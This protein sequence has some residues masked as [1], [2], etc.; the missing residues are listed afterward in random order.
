MDLIPVY[1]SRLLTALL[2]LVLV[3][4]SCEATHSTRDCPQTQQAFMAFFNSGEHHKISSLFKENSKTKTQFK[5]LAQDLEYMREVA[6]KILSMEV[7]YTEGNKVHYKSTLEATALDISFIYNAKCQLTSLLIKNHFPEDLP[8]LERNSTSM[9]LPFHGEWY[10][11][12]GGPTVAQ[13]YHNAHQ[14][15]RGAFDFVMIDQRGKSYNTDGKKNEDYYAFG[16]EII[17]PCNAKV[18]RVIRGIKDNVW[19]NMNTV[20]A[21]GNAV[22]LK[23]KGNEFLFFAH[24][25]EKSIVV[26]EGDQV[27]Q[28]QKLGLCGNSGYSTEPHLHFNLQ[29]VADLFDPTGAP[30]Y[31]DNI[32][33]DGQPRQDY[34]PVRGERIQNQKQ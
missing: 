5:K 14:N 12:W 4:G 8:L 25:K 17:A 13:N 11:F 20:K 32:L 30:C 29:N 3:V 1:S 18:V 19:P 15:M 27:V 23:T 26:N 6:G 31:F 10:V 34:S 7:T 22:I 16:Q 21:H 28:G 2:P 9:A 24:L 33:V